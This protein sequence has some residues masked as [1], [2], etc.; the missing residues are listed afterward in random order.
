MID[1][2]R[3]Q[4]HARETAL[5]W[6]MRMQAEPDNAALRHEFEQWCARSDE[7][8]LAYASVMRVLKVAK[9]LPAN[10]AAAY[11]RPGVAPVSRYSFVRPK[12]L[13]ARPY[14]AAAGLVALAGLCIV[15]FGTFRAT[16]V[17]GTLY[18][19]AVAETRK[20]SLDDG[21]TLFLDAQTRTR[22]AMS[23]AARTVELLGGEAYFDVAADRERPFI[24]KAG[25]LTVTVTGT[26]FAVTNRGNRLAVAVASGSVEAA[27]DADSSTL[28]AGERVSLH[29]ARHTAE[30]AA[31]DPDSIGTFRTGRVLA[32]NV[33]F[34]ELIE[35][36]DAHYDGDIWLSDPALADKLIS[37]SFD[38]NDPVAALRAAAGSQNASVRQ[39]SS[40]VLAVFS[41]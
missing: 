17:A 36:L 14:P 32:Q 33:P 10:Y 13:R 19:T 34:G 5:D 11:R 6:L 1:D 35:Q 25:E 39:L 30:T 31:V 24:V 40:D 15:L 27:H 29:G 4:T 26:R 23:E 8:R 22:V 38:L 3:R 21:S 12:F 9:E 41:R 37:G 18:E 20:I 16:P 7:N 2:V 28:S